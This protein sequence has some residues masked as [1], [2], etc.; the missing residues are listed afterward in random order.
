MAVCLVEHVH[1]SRCVCACWRGARQR[2][3]GTFYELDEGQYSASRDGGEAVLVQDGDVS[4]SLFLGG[5]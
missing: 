2:S 3:G 1:S 5:L 4:R